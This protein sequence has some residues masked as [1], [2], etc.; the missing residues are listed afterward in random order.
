MNDFFFLSS[1]FTSRRWE[2]K[3]MKK[4]I[5]EKLEEKKTKK[6]MGISQDLAKQ[7]V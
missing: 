1:S 7:G 2:D 5:S 3:K 4:R 6:Q